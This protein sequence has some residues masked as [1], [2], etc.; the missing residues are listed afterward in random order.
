MITQAGIIIDVGTPPGPLSDWT[1]ATVRFHGF[2]ELTT[3]KDEVIESPEFMLLQNRWTVQIFPGGHEESEEIFTAVYL[4]N[5]SD[6]SIDVEF[7]LTVEDPNP[8]GEDIIDDYD[9][10]ISTFAPGGTDAEEEVNDS[11]WGNGKF[12]KREKLLNYLVDGTLIVKVHMGTTTNIATQFISRNPLN[13][14]ILKK[15]NQESDADVVFEVRGQEGEGSGIH[16]RV[17]T[18]STTFH[19]HHLILE[20]IRS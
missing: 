10:E 11:T 4:H 14:N 7:N 15:F 9:H 17:K 2:K 8:P 13:E 5:M 18:A 12:S 16:K 3:Q 6:K 20:A 19:A 1:T